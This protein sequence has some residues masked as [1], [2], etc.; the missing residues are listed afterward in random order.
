MP[1]F[2]PAEIGDF[3]EVRIRGQLHGQTTI[4]TFRYDVTDAFTDDLLD[5]DA[6]LSN[7]ENELFESIRLI[8]SVQQK[9]IT[10]EAQKIS[11]T[12]LIARVRQPAAIEGEV[13]GISLTSGAAW[14]FRR[15]LLNAGRFAQGRIYLPGVPAS[16]TLESQILPA[17]TGGVLV[18]DVIEKL[19][20]DIVV[21]DGTLR[22][23]LIVPAAGN[24][25]ANRGRLF[26]IVVDP[27]IRYQ[28]RREVGVGQ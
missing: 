18:A 25:W 12:R 21:N 13:A 28:R 4:T 19:L 14:V 11:P 16:Y 10:L 27:I 2:V 26:D 20:E 3:F 7:V 8:T 5:L 9:Y 1:F 23:S 22:P 24:T 15:K 17:I 6:V